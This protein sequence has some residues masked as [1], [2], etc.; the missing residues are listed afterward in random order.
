V[1]NLAGLTDKSEIE[2]STP[3]GNPSSRIHLGSL[4]GIRVAFIARHDVGHRLLPTE[5]PYRA[6]IYALK[7]LGVKYLLSFGACGSLA[8]ENK[9]MDVVLVDQFIDRTKGFREHTFF[10]QGLIGHVSMA[11]PVCGIFSKTIHEAVKE[12]SHPALQSLQIHQGGT[13]VCIEGPTFSTKA[14]SKMYR[15][16]GGTVIG[17]TAIPEALLAKEAEISYALVALVTDYDC[18]HPAHDSVTV[19]MV[20]ANLHHNSATAQALVQEV[21]RRVGKEKFYSPFHDSL[22]YALVTPKDRIG[23]ELKK[24]TAPH[25]FQIHFPVNVCLR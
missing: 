15:L 4:D 22:K 23:D 8:E 2:V 13:Y 6:N 11:D 18:W 3:F 14:E 16:L 1:Y 21:I 17:M 19:D 12:S 10:G 9:P 5:I 25:Y 24:K 20:M 7:S